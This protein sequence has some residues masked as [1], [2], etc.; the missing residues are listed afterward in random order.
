MRPFAPAGQLATVLAVGAIFAATLAPPAGA[1]WSAPVTV[2]APHSQIGDVQLVSGPGGEMLSWTSWDL[3]LPQGIFGP[4][5]THYAL[6]PA[7]GAFGREQPLPASDA[8]N[9]IVNMGGGHLAHLLLTRTSKSTSTEKPEVALG[10]TTGRFG[11]PLQIR[12]ATVGWGQPSLAGNARGALLL[13][14][15][16]LDAH[17]RRMVWASIRLP[18]GSFGRPQVIAAHAQAEQV[19]AAVGSNG[20]MAVTFP[21]KWGRLLARVRRHG[22]QW[23]PLQSLGPAAGGNENDLTPFITGSGNVLVA[24]YETQLCEGGCADPGFTRVAVQPAGASHFR[25]AQL[26]ERD[27]TG[28]V[29]SASGRSLAPIVLSVGSQAPMVIFLARGAPPPQG[30]ALTPAV[31]R[32]ASPRGL[33]FSAPQ[34]ISPADE[35][36]GEVAAAAGPSGTIVSWIRDEPPSYFGGSLFAALRGTSGGFG[37]PEQV[38]PNEH[39]FTALPV[40]NLASRWPGNSI[41]P[42]TLAW[43]SRPLSEASTVVRVSSPLCPDPACVGA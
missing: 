39:V 43:T 4:P 11:S 1:A 9:P 12:G 21:N 13:A 42:W 7:G 41:A 17:Q 22:Q 19:S 18:G 5:S 37:A 40:F 33:G 8:F 2:S 38:S 32:V 28:L 25:R 36:A 35:Q 23:G 26:L 24:W 15:I 6:A 30:S 29:G 14:W 20:D 31:V 10:S 27:A 34:T 16:A 3:M